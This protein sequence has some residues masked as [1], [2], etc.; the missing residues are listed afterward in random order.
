MLQGTRKPLVV[1][2]PKSLLRNRAATSDLSFLAEGRFQQVIDDRRCEEKEAVQ[3]VV[4]CSGK[5]FYELD[6]K[7]Q[8]DQVEGL[9]LVRIEQL[10]PFPEKELIEV[11]GRYPGADEI[12]WCQE[13]PKNQG[14]WY[15]IRHHLQRSVRE[16]QILYY[17]GRRR[18][19]SPAT[20]HYPVHLAEQ[21]GLVARALT[22]GEGSTL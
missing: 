17:V 14:A 1:M 12:V 22:P 18:S 3:R 6:A 15:Q 5:V 4:L 21:E 11:L 8:E 10:H 7:R 20:G 13:E 16:G 2:M 9:A 19:P